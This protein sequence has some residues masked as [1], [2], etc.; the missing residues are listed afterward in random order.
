MFY[1]YKK[2]L[3]L[4]QTNKT[5]VKDRIVK[6]ASSRKRVDTP[7]LYLAEARLIKKLKRKSEAI[8]KE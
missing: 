4:D 2:M 7:D 3:S 5:L 8:S 6:T 1:L